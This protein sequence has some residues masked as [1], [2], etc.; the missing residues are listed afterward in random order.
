[1][2]TELNFVGCTSI[3]IDY[4]QRDSNGKMVFNIYIT[5]VK[6]RVLKSSPNSKKEQ[7]KDFRWNTKTNYIN[8]TDDYTIYLERHTIAF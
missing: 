5:N 1:M 2:F 6:A 4:T 3:N 7:T 8:V